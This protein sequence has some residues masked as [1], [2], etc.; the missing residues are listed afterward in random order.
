MFSSTKGAGA[1]DLTNGN[2]PAHAYGI[3]KVDADKLRT[4][5]RYHRGRKVRHSIRWQIYATKM[6]IMTSP[7]GR[8]TEITKFVVPLSCGVVAMTKSNLIRHQV[9]RFT[10]RLG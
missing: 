4:L 6:R 9:I 2:V 3:P 1:H 5:Q 8:P 10:G 7:I